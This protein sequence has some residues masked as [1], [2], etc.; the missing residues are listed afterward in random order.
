M[1]KMTSSASFR[2]YAFLYGTAPLLLAACG[3]GTGETTAG[4]NHT[5]T[6]ISDG[7][8]Q[9]SVASSAGASP[10]ADQSRPDIFAD[11]HA[12]P[13]AHVDTVAPSDADAAAGLAGPDANVENVALVGS[14]ADAREAGAPASSGAA[15][16]A[17]ASV[18]SAGADLASAARRSAYNYYVAP[19]GSD[20]AAGTSDKPFRTL[21]RAARAVRA[22]S[23]VWVAPGIY[24]GG[25]MVKTSG[26]ESGRINF[27]STRR[28]AAKIVPPALSTRT[29]AFDVRGNYVSVIG[30]DVDGSNSKAGKKWLSGIYVGG[31]YGM[32]QGNHVHHIAQSVSCNSGGG[33]AIGADGYYH[34]EHIDVI[35]NTVHDI[36]PAG[37]SFVQGIYMSTSGSVKNNVVF[38]VAEAAIHLWHDARD[39]SITGNTV[40]GSNTGIIVGG[41]NFY[42]TS[43][44]ADNT[45]VNNNIVYDN[46]IG[47]SEQGK[48]GKSNKYM[49]NLVYKNSINWALKKGM[50]HSGSVAAEPQFVSYT[51]NGSANFRIAPVS[52]AVG[53]GTP[54][55][56]HPVDIESR[57]RNATT[58]YDIGAYQH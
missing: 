5:A 24:E 51:R 54:V 40:S 26:T 12:E 37:C 1:K 4:Q 33:S 15:V 42:F 50:A 31:S 29:T 57:P 17:Q 7:S 46:K 56:A 6:V 20:S 30:F 52:P 38:R 14:Q 48:T 53:G 21:A 35:G 55:D 34:G 32:V 49:N 39:L 28:G 36:G 58:G 45:T 8:G 16:P 2:V 25:V 3:G 22:N 9:T 43:G 18:D 19:E 13:D 41:G 10:A 47:I 44:G 23:T 27:V 11:A